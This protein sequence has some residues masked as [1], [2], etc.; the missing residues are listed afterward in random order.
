MQG[1]HH[2]DSC[3]VLASIVENCEETE[4]GKEAKLVERRHYQGKGETFGRLEWKERKGTKE[5]FQA[6]YKGKGEKRAKENSN[7]YSS[8]HLRYAL[9]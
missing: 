1:S 8:I 2:Y 7:T 4:R 9:K 6:K 3:A 5:Q